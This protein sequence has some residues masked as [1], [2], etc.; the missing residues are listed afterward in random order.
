[1]LVPAFKEFRR[2]DDQRHLTLALKGF[3]LWTSSTATDKRRQ[4]KN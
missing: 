1:M 2:F 3:E 4:I